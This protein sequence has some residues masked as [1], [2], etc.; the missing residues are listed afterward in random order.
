MIDANE[1]PE[2]L[3][4]IN[5]WYSCFVF[6]D[7][8]NSGTINFLEMHN[9]ITCLGLVGLS[10]AFTA[11][12]LEKYVCAGSHE[13]RFDNFILACVTLCRFN[14]TYKFL[15]SQFG[16]PGRLPQKLEQVT[17]Y[18]NNCINIYLSKSFIVSFAGHLTFF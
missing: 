14:E 13:I 9:A 3:A 10:D 16:T 18:S 6:L 15:E 8:D 5:N 1:F 11:S 7:S 4:Y 17:R 12:L 2:M